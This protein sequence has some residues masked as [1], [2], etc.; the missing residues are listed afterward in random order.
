MDIKI[1]H[2]EDWLKWKNL[3]LEALYQHP[4][5]FGSSYEEEC[6]LSDNEFKKS[7]KKE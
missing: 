4:E 2:Q 1:L 7:L 3:R 6:N 5:A